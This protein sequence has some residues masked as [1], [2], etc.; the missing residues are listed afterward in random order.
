MYWFHIPLNHKMNPAN[1]WL[2]FCSSSVELEDNSP[3]VVRNWHGQTFGKCCTHFYLDWRRRR[4]IGRRKLF[5]PDTVCIEYFLY[6]FFFRSE[7]WIIILL[8]HLL[9]LYLRCNDIIMNIAGAIL[10]FNNSHIN[11][12]NSKVAPMII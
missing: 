3:K 11:L 12:L 5:L 1:N 10:R 8:L 6:L 9:R 4:R 7:F 2:F